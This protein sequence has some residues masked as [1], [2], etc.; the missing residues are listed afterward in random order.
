MEE[1]G[2]NLLSAFLDASRTFVSSSMRT[3]VQNSVLVEVL[4]P[5]APSISIKL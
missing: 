3:A 2:W 5:R 4:R 1:L